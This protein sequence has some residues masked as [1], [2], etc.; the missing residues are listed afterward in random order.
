MSIKS[1]SSH[2][3]IKMPGFLGDSYDQVWFRVKNKLGQTSQGY[4]LF[5]MG[6]HGLG[7][8]A[9]TIVDYSRR[10]IKLPKYGS[11]GHSNN[12]KS[13]QAL[14][15]YVFNACSTLDCLSFALYI[16]GQEISTGTSGSLTKQQLRSITKQSAAELYERLW[17]LEEV[18]KTLV[19]IRDDVALEMLFEIRDVLIHRGALPHTLHVG[20]STGVK[21]TIPS[22]LKEI[23]DLWSSDFEIGT[24]TVE[25]WQSVVTSHLHRVVDRLMVFTPLDK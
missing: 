20:V 16:V 14:T 10:Y 8:R 25:D 18:T 19:E 21:V 5:S 2:L 15:D 7:Y 24:Q 17:P 13:E 9:V 12:Y 4:R 3:G 1:T 6:W 22:N 11:A 23:P